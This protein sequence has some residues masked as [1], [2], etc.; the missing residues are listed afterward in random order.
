MILIFLA[1]NI[2]LWNTHTNIKTQNVFTCNLVS[3]PF[4]KF[5]LFSSEVGKSWY[6]WCQGEELG[7]NFSENGFWPLGERNWSGKRKRPKWVCLDEWIYSSLLVPVFASEV[8][9]RPESWKPVRLMQPQ[10]PGTL[11]IVSL[12]EQPILI[13]FWFI[14]VS[15][16]HLKRSTLGVDH[17]VFLWC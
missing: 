3:C 11:C 13:C 15:F 14:I 12:E 4:G 7:G 1:P 9:H 5:H 6:F 2:Y 16:P 10:K 17:K 8:K